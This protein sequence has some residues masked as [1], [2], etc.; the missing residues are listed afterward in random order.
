MGA[1]SCVQIFPVLLPQ[2]GVA[3]ALRSQGEVRQASSMTD[4][5]HLQQGQ[6]QTCRSTDAVES[7]TG[8]RA[9]YKDMRCSGSV[10]PSRVKDT[11]NAHI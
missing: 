8:I 9:R 4:L 6:R 2:P 7:D 10:K 3:A 5:K 1:W 11:R